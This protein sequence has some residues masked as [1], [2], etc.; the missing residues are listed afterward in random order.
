MKQ[1]IKYGFEATFL[2]GEKRQLVSFNAAT[3]KVEIAYDRMNLERAMTEK[4][5]RVVRMERR[6][7]LDK[8][9]K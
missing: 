2:D 7:D 1:N 5:L 9:S 3:A 8:E 4:Q 6:P